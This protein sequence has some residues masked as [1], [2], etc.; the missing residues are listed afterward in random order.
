M[1]YS[2]FMLSIIFF[3]VYSDYMLI[4]V[5]LLSFLCI[6]SY[7]IHLL[8]SWVD[9]RCHVSMVLRWYLPENALYMSSRVID[10]ESYSPVESLWSPPPIY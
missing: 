3:I 9:G 7:N 8:V 4:I 5:G 6:S 2:I 10:H 1:L